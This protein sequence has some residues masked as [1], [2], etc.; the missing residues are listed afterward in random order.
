MVRHSPDAEVHRL[1]GDDA[2]RV[3][4]DDALEAIAE[5]LAALL[6]RS[7]VPPQAI[8]RARMALAAIA[9]GDLPVI[10]DELRIAASSLPT[11]Q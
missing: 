4:L 11:L 6:E 3:H 7:R 1:R 9:A 2:R 8:E 5:V 10:D